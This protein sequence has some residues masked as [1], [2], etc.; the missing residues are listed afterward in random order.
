MPLSHL[1]VCTRVCVC[2]CVRIPL[3]DAPLAWKPDWLSLVLSSEGL[4]VVGVFSYTTWVLAIVSSPLASSWTARSG[5]ISRRPLAC[6]HPW[7]RTCFTCVTAWH[8]S[9]TCDP[10]RLP[11]SP[12]S[13]RTSPWAHWLHHR[14]EARPRQSREALSVQVAKG[15][16]SL[17][18]HQGITPDWHPPTCHSGH[19]LLQDCVQ[20][21]GFLSLLEVL[22]RRMPRVCECEGENH[23]EALASL[24]VSSAVT[25]EWPEESQVRQPLLG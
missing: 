16:S 18:P 13:T 6:T 8:H 12:S 23:G 9:S 15:K 17:C 2:A 14:C 21:P 3:A 11:T 7:R 1:C 5:G 25:Y 24:T 19:T 20:Q 4:G 10:G 22:G